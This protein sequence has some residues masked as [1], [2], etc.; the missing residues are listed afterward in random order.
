[1]KKIKSGLLQAGPEAGPAAPR[2]P[3]ARVR[4][5]PGYASAGHASAGSRRSGRPA[6]PGL[7]VCGPRVRGLAA[8]TAAPGRRRPGAA[9]RIPVPADRGGADRPGAPRPTAR[10]AAADRRLG[11]PTQRRPGAG[12]AR[13][14]AP[15]VPG[16][17]GRE[18]A[19]PL[20]GVA[21]AG[22]GAGRP[23]AAR[24]VAGRDLRPHRRR[25]DGPTV[26]PA[27]ARRSTVP[28]AR[29]R[30]DSPRS[31]FY[32]ALPS[33][34]SSSFSTPGTPSPELW[35]R[36]FEPVDPLVYSVHTYQITHLPRRI[37]WKY[38]MDNCSLFGLGGAGFEENPPLQC[39]YAL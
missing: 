20:R 19:Q 22:L 13:G 25:D 8:A 30:G 4:T 6:G 10:G 28:R 29:G 33:S 17:R 3:L 15:G 34:S 12:A 26:D 31:A 35:S 24:D 39:N 16:L 21:A 9:A 2:R 11:P 27:P 5:D 18:A 14:R 1:M 7:R 23:R 32:H 36:A 38:R 37:S